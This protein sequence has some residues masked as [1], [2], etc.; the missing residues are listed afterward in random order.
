MHHVAIRQ[1]IIDR[2]L[3]RRQRYHIFDQ[4]AAD[5]TALVVIDM[6]S[7][8]MAPGSPAEVPASRGIVENIN[9]LAVSLRARGAAVIWVT[10]ANS[11][12]ASGSDWN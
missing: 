9:K 10:H 8:F 5:E 6:Q 2:L 4:F 1:E 7:T 11:R 12:V 3:A